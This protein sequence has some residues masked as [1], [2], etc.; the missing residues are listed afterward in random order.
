MIENRFFKVSSNNSHHR[1]IYLFF[2][3]MKV[4]HGDVSLCILYYMYIENEVSFPCSPMRFEQK[5]KSKM[6]NV[7]RIVRK[8]LYV[9]LIL[10]YLL[11][12]QIARG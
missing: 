5:K 1:L 3:E 2:I 4:V 12:K 10:C 6:S 8:N 7:N 11:G 9:I